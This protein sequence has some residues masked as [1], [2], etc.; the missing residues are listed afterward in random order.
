[1]HLGHPLL[2]THRDK[3]KAYDFIYQK[4]KSRLT[5]TKANTL[6]HAGRLTLIQSVFA[7]IP[8]YYMANILFIKK[9]LANLTAIIRTFWWQGVQKDQ[10]KKPIHYR[11]WDACCKPKK[12]GGLGIRKLELVNKGMLI[13]T[14]WRFINEPETMV[15][16]IIK[17]KY[18]PNASLW[19][20]SAHIPK[21]TFWSSI[22]S[23]RHHLETHVTI[24][25]IDGNTSIW[26]QPWSPFWKEMH[27][28]LNLEQ[29]DYE[30]PSTVSDLWLPNSKM[31]DENKIITLFGQQSMD[32]LVQV[33]II[34]GQGPDIICWKLTPNGLCSS[35]SAY[36]MLA[37]EEAARHPPPN[38]PLQVIQIL[39]HVWKDKLI[40]PR[41]KTFAWRL[42]RLALGTG[43][44]LH[45][46]IHRIDEKCSRCGMVEDDNHLFFE[47]SFARATWFASV[48]G[49]RTSNLPSSTS[50]LHVQIA[51]LLQQGVP[52]VT[53]GI[54]F[55]IMWCLWKARNDHRFNN[56]HW[57]TSRILFEATAIDNSLAAAMEEP[58]P[59]HDY[60]N[61]GQDNNLSN[62]SVQIQDGPKIFCDASVCVQQSAAN[63]TGIGIFILT[64]PSHSLCSASFFQVRILQAMEPLQAEA[65]A[66]LMGAKL[67]RALNLQRANLITDNEVL[68][69]SARTASAGH[70]PGHW[71]LRPFL[72]EFADVT[73]GITCSIIK[74]SRQNNKVADRL[75]K[76]AR[77]ASIPSPCLFSCNALSHNL[78]CPVRHALVNFQ[79]GS[80]APISLTCL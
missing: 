21:S 68:A 33:P 23:I 1:M 54:I 69:K 2:I 53:A 57:T 6:N 45:R 48:L 66:L 51:T 29:T 7:S 80:F 39:R 52:H 50:G 47:C 32:A 9:F 46:I 44:R 60:D 49:L 77:Q 59:I 30:I 64:T 28:R 4:F 19:T 58:L 65:N 11:S 61:Q 26:N 78:H 67:A 63:Q 8:I 38:T 12:E 71:S 15:A 62:V 76:M 37:R 3:D 43:K 16:K 10:N 55:S 5:L 20:A 27:D 41:V 70:S 73:Q 42:L 34:V 74:I 35:K 31:W 75:A 56:V 17:A 14:A 24:Q 72:A 40:Q 18:F 79:W 13:N 25:F 36:N 22:L